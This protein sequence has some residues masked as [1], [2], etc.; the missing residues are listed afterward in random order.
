MNIFLTIQTLLHT[1]GGTN[2]TKEPQGTGTVG[3]K[4]NIFNI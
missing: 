3:S 2:A 4:F 1:I